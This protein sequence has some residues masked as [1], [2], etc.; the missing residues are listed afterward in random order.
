MRAG[1]CNIYHLMDSPLTLLFALD[2]HFD[3]LLFEVG[4]HWTNNRFTVHSVFS[5]FTKLRYRHHRECH[6]L[7]C[8]LFVTLKKAREQHSSLLIHPTWKC[9]H[10][11]WSFFS[12]SN[13]C[14][15]TFHPSSDKFSFF[16]FW[17]SLDSTVRC[18]ARKGRFMDFIHKGNSRC[19]IQIEVNKTK[20]NIV[21][22]CTVY[23]MQIA[24]I[25]RK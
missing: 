16:I 11:T 4:Q 10:W 2:A 7:L 6:Q 17:Y 19:F 20:Q 9:W 5:H 23:K 25:Y 15:K 3:L 22:K 21:W 1:G 18:K 8:T 12:R 24:V 14:H 13:Y